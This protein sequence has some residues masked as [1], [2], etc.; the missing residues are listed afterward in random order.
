MKVSS[1]TCL[2]AGVIALALVVGTAASATAQAVI[3]NGSGVA[4]GVN[5]AGHLNTAGPFSTINSGSQIGVAFFTD[6]N[7]DGS[8][9]WGDATAPGC[10]CE[11]WGVSADAVV[12]RASIANGGIS[13]LTVDSFVSDASS[14]TSVVH[15]TSLA[16]LSV[17]H[18]YV[19]SASPGL[20]QANISISNTTGADITSLRYRRVMDWDIPPTTFSELVT[21]QGVG[22]GDLVDSCDDGFEVPDPLAACSGISAPAN[23]NLVDSGPADHGASFTFDFGALA[24]GATKTFSIFYG[25]TPTEAAAFAALAAVGAE[26]IYSFGQSSGAAGRTSGAPA[27]FIFGFGGVGAPPIG[28]PEPATLFLL[29]GGLA[30]MMIRRYRRG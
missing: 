14:A 9:E 3:Q 25:A 16:G 28:A 7:G 5:Q 18:A 4:L 24:N 30:T 1:V 26:G 6:Y 19:P 17:T 29:G 27:T 13:N 22:L 23:T 12:G 20:Y 15:L 11:G 8:S 2:R 10:L 21:L